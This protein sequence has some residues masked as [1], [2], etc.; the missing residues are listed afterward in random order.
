MVN[1][2]S[3]LTV[4]NTNAYVNVTVTTYICLSLHICRHITGKPNLIFKTDNMFLYRSVTSIFLC[5]EGNFQGCILV[6]A[7]S[8]TIL[9]NVS[10]V[11]L[12]NPINNMVFQYHWSFTSLH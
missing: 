7:D 11:L 6:V 4:T 1:L 12:D 10:Y 2:L 8:S 5:L 3:C 9:A